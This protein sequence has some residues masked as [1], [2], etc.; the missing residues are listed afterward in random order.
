MTPR[1]FD[2]HHDTTD[3]TRRLF[4]R[5]LFLAAICSALVASAL[6]PACGPSSTQTEG[7]STAAPANTNPPAAPATPAATQA[8]S[9]AAPAAVT[10]PLLAVFECESGTIRAE[11]ATKE[12]PRLCANFINLVNRG[13]YDGQAWV[14]FS[15]VVRQ[16]GLNPS[17]EPAYSLPRE[18][19]TNLFFDKPGR[20]CFSNNS[21][22]VSTARSKPTRIFITVRPQ[23]RWNLQYAVFGTIVEGLD[24]AMNL[25]EGEKIIRVKIEG[26][27]TAHQAR[28][29]KQIAEWNAALDA[30]GLLDRR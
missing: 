25:K 12:A 23:D 11:L 16:T 3:M 28:Y 7:A 8:D 26:D 19:G 30:V 29:A 14:D 24:V 22:D 6:L 18:F 10:A 9:P 20:L 4:Q 13:Y 27:T 15:R 17:G 21:D 2:L 1:T 5:F